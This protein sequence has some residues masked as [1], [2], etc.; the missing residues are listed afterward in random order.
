MNRLEGVE[1]VR[2]NYSGERS[3]VE[4]ADLT[5]CS[6]TNPTISGGILMSTDI[7]NPSSIA[8]EAGTT[9]FVD[10]ES[11]TGSELLDTV[12]AITKLREIYPEHFI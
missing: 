11:F 4:D 12:K 2:S 1:I 8:I 9:I 10:G 3:R 6:V 7:S 5:N